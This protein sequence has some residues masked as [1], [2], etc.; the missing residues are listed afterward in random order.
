MTEVFLIDLRFLVDMASN[1]YHDRLSQPIACNYVNWVLSKNIVSFE[2]RIEE[3]DSIIIGVQ[4]MDA[5][6]KS[7]R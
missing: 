2:G 6:A 4:L 3:F 1:C 5:K 7:S